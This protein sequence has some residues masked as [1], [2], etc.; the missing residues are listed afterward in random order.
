M[1]VPPGKVSS[2]QL[3][4]GGAVRKYLRVAEKLRE[5]AENGSRYLEARSRFLQKHRWQNEAAR[6]RAAI[7]ALMG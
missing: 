4:R 7:A 3:A 2:M 5:V 1:P 6:V